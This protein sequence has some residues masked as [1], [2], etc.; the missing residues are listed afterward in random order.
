MTKETLANV[1]I[2]KNSTYGKKAPAVI[3]SQGAPEHNKDPQLTISAHDKAENYIAKMNVIRLEK[4][5]HD[6]QPKSKSKIEKAK[7]TFR[8]VKK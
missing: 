5:K 7:K 1:I 2:D 3:T 8:G 6:N 4:I